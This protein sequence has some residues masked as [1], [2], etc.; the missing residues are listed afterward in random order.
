VQLKKSPLVAVVAAGV[1]LVL[2]AG[3]CARFPAIR[4]VVTITGQS[5]G[6]QTIKDQVPPNNTDCPAQDTTQHETATVSYKA[7]FKPVIVPLKKT[8]FILKFTPRGRGGVAGGSF[9]YDGTYLKDDP[10]NPDA[11]PALTATSASAK[12][13]GK[14]LP[15]PTWDGRSLSPDDI[16]YVGYLGSDVS[17]IRAT[18]SGLAVPQ[19]ESSGDPSQLIPIDVAQDL[20]LYDMEYRPRLALQALDSSVVVNWN[21]LQRKVRPL[22]HGR[23]VTLAVSS[24][25]DNS[26]KP[27]PFHDDCPSVGPPSGPTDFGILSCSESMTLHYTIKIRKLG[28]AQG[29]DVATAKHC[30]I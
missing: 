4:A 29:C 12:L 13:A 5:T 11:C 20:P 19:D 24:S 3:A 17:D 18:P 23:T 2:P 8:G 21:K 27:V 26:H 16:F 14:K 25:L 28:P 7:T 30:L 9:N 15:V 22:A 10:N 6:Q 1:A